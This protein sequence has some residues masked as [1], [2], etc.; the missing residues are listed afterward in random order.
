[1]SAW[2]IQPQEATTIL[3]AVSGHVGDEEGTEGLT[4]HMKSL[5]THLNE[6]DSAAAS[7]PIGVALG[8]LAAHYFGEI[9]DMVAI[10][11][12]AVAGAG[13]AILHYTNGNLEMAA[14]SQAHAGEMPDTG[15]GGTNFFY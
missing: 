11:S 15:L 1:M 10:S 6:A 4:G 12:S 13:E 2:N 7:A 8:E 5:E 14:E 3:S 9:G